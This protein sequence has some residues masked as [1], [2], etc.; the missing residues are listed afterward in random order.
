MT[1]IGSAEFLMIAMSLLWAGLGFGLAIALVMA[2][3]R[4]MKALERIAS[5][6]EGQTRSPK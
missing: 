2:I 1:S 6:L 5:A 3:W 4:A